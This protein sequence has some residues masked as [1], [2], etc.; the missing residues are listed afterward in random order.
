MKSKK[1]FV[2]TSDGAKNIATAASGLLKNNLDGHKLHLHPERVAKW[3]QAERVAPICI[4]M[5]ITQTFNIACK[6]CYYMVPKNRTQ[7]IIPTRQLIQFLK[8]SA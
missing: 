6:F 2:I 4:D 1:L 7:H 3:K 5:G 8:E